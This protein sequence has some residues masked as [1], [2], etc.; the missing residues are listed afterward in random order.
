MSIIRPTWVIEDDR[1]L[2]SVDDPVFSALSSIDA[3]IIPGEICKE[4]RRLTNLTRIPDKNCPVIF[5]GSQPFIQ[6]CNSQ[7]P[8]LFPGSRWTIPVNFS[9][10]TYYTKYKK[11]LLND[12]FLVCP[13]N[14][15]Y[16]KFK[17]VFARFD[18]HSLFIRPNDHIKLFN[19]KIVYLKNLL[20]GNWENIPTNLIMDNL[21]LISPTKKIIKEFRF[22]LTRDNV[23]SCS[24]YEN[25]FEHEFTK[26]PPQEAIVFANTIANNPWIPSPIFA[27]DIALL[28][29]GDYK[30]I[31]LNPFNSCSFYNADIPRILIEAEKIAVQSHSKL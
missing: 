17:S 4:S 23:I 15:F 19:G 7:F 24:E 9:C 11:Y 14:F 8:D 27:L 28:E 30:I 21:V 12:I 2:N 25:N 3:K 10:D 31:E 1:Y 26:K 13:F 22:F 5:Y 29:G 18:T 16:E 20:E 6:S